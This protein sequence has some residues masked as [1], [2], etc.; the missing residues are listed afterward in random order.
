MVKR[1]R[2][3]HHRIFPPTLIHHPF[4]DG[5]SVSM[6]GGYQ[7]PRVGPN[8]GF[9]PAGRGRALRGGVGALVAPHRPTLRAERKP[10]DPA[11]HARPEPGGSAPDTKC[12]P[13]PVLVPTRVHLLWFFSLTQ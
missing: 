12:H 10:P 8:P 3:Q 1:I 13:R 11:P 7:W 4:A 2:Q 6:V 5:L 9:G